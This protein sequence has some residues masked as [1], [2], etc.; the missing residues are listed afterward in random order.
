MQGRLGLTTSQ[1]LTEYK[2]LT[3][4]IFGHSRL[5]HVRNRTWLGSKYDSGYLERIIDNLV[6]RYIRNADHTDNVNHTGNAN[7]TDS[8]DNPEGCIRRPT[9]LDSMRSSTIR[10]RR[11]VEE[12][13]SPF[14][15]G[16]PYR[17]T[18]GLG[19]KT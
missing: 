5:F 12:F 4:Q 10:R 8:A 6:N 17:G 18:P 1:C 2:R 19:C 15:N 7:H 14:Q 11:Q 13:L 16:E 3:K 9:R